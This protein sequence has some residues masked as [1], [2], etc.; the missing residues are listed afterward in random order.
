MIKLINYHEKLTNAFMSK[1]NQEFN[2]ND[3][4]NMINKIIITP[5]RNLRSYF[6]KHDRPGSKFH[7]C[8][9]LFKI[10][11]IIISV[12]LMTLWLINGITGYSAAKNIDIVKARKFKNL[13]TCLVIYK[14]IEF[15][16]IV[17]IFS[18][19]A[20]NYFKEHDFT[21]KLNDKTLF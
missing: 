2:T 7:H 4:D 17:S 6:R 14:I 13:N 19:I 9:K 1:F 16:V 12:I 15:I 10:L 11:I 18:F 5:G 8:S 3:L 20:I 21:V